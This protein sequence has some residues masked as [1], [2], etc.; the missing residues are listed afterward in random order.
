MPVQLSRG[1]KKARPVTSPSHRPPRTLRPWTASARA[2]GPSTA[3]GTRAGP[4]KADIIASPPRAARSVR[5]GRRA[6]GM[7]RAGPSG[8]VAGGSSV[9]GAVAT[10]V[11][12]GNRRPPTAGFPAA[13]FAPRSGRTGGRDRR[14]RRRGPD[15][16]S[17]P[18]AS[19]GRPSRPGP[20]GAGVVPR[21]EGRRRTAHLG[22]AS[23]GRTATH[24]LRAARPLSD[25]ADLGGLRRCCRTLP[26]V[27]RGAPTPRIA[28]PARAPSVP[29]EGPARSIRGG[30]SR[31]SR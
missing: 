3:S 9:P 8:S 15:P 2:A 13:G 23:S 17:H 4:G 18:G 28:R 25:D 30:T 11:L 5:H 6:P 27:S 24:W 16:A 21:P 31:C 20:G 26:R 22:P 19:G 1:T 14:T 10:L 12:P 7:R 29:A